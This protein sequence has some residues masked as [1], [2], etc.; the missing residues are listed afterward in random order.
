MERL[1]KA[2]VGATRIAIQS[3]EYPLARAL[4]SIAQA[5]AIVELAGREP[6]LPGIPDEAR[7]RL[8]CMESDAPWRQADLIAVLQALAKPGQSYR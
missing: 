4:K 2:R 5:T 1:P 6:G 7:A 8:V 3:I